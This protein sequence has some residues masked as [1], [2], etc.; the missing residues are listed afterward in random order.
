MDEFP[1]G[2]D[3]DRG[4]GVKA[5][6]YLIIYDLSPGPREKLSVLAAFMEMAEERGLLWVLQERDLVYQAPNDAVWGEFPGRKAAIQAFDQTM[7]A[8]SKLLGYRLKL[9]R[10][11]VTVLDDS[12]I[13]SDAAKAVNPKLIGASRF[14]T[15][16]L[17]Q[18]FDPPRSS[19]SSGRMV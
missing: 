1:R 19:I 9:N 16:R 15:S 13:W 8:T 14:E 7:D 17:H 6:S 4:L 3:A 2:A 12:W 5:K 18:L 11:I 10:R